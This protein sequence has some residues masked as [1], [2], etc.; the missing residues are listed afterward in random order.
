M[1]NFNGNLIKEE[2]SKTGVCLNNFFINTLVE[3]IKVDFNKLC[4]FEVHYFKLMASMRMFSLKIPM[5]FT[6]E[7]LEHQILKTIKSNDYKNNLKVELFVSKKILD[8]TPANQID[9]LIRVTPLTFEIINENYEVELFKDFYINKDKLSN[10]NFIANPLLETAK[11]FMLD[12]NYDNVLLLNND[13]NIVEAIDC[14]LF[15]ILGNNIITPPLTDGCKN[16]I[17][18]KKIIDIV[19]N[20]NV[21]KI[22]ER[23]VSP[24][25]IQKCDEIFLT[26]TLN[27]V[28]SVKKYRK[29]E[30]KSTLGEKLSRKLKELI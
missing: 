16:G 23:S 14:N 27:G 29:K 13:K 30:F 1:L 28:I 22:I 4:F 2:K 15:L 24:F 3:V 9:F 5:Y 11:N 25:E 12:F 6:Q 18:R 8:K 19:K 21:L 17:I 7:F 26:N 20:D 10:L